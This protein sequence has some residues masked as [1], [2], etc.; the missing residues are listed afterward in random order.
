M[1]SKP[2]TL[3]AKPWSW[4]VKPWSWYAQ[5]YMLSVLVFLFLALATWTSTLGTR[6]DV[7]VAY[8]RSGAIEAARLC[9]SEGHVI[10][11]FLIIHGGSFGY[12][13]FSI[14]RARQ[15][16]WTTNPTSP[17]KCMDDNLV[18]HHA[19]PLAPITILFHCAYNSAQIMVWQTM[20]M[21]W[22]PWLMLRFHGLKQWIA[23]KCNCFEI[24]YMVWY[25]D[26]VQYHGL[27]PWICTNYMVWI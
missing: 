13:M 22:K 15:N 5:N 17:P 21:A 25:N 27:K 14:L 11:H 20:F 16:A 4:L 8:W 19:T 10:C 1:V 7:V 23:G 3:F 9:H 2:W 24:T 18:P 12:K 6:F 26:F